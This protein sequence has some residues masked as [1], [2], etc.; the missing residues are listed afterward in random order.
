MLGVARNELPWVQPRTESLFFP[1][2]KLTHCRRNPIILATITITAGPKPIRWRIPPINPERNVGRRVRQPHQGIGH[3]GVRSPNH[4]EHIQRNIGE[5]HKTIAQ[6]PIRQDGG[7]RGRLR[8]NQCAKQPH[9]N[10]FATRG[11]HERDTSK[12]ATSHHSLGG[13]RRYD[14]ALLCRIPGHEVRIC[15]D[16]PSFQFQTR[17]GSGAVLQGVASN[18]VSH[19]VEG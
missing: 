9:V 18:F 19:Q 8:R 11:Q 7:H 5:P 2:E 6:D 14:E 3:S 10:R 17:W 15:K 1:A 12:R 16:R 4:M 13:C